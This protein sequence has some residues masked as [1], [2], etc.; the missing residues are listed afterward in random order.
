MGLR[1]FYI[2]FADCDVVGVELH[3]VNLG[4]QLEPLPG[5]ARLLLHEDVAHVHRRG[6]D[7]HAVR[8]QLE[9]CTLQ[10]RAVLDQGVRLLK[11]GH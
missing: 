5:S 3:A 4:N 2:P 10:L 1:Q 7:C 8:A 6:D 11:N 9:L